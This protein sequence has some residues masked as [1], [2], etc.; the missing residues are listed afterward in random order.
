MRQVERT[1]VHVMPRFQTISED[2][3]A[4]YPSHRQCSRAVQVFIDFM[5]EW[6]RSHHVN[7]EALRALKSEEVLPVHRLS[8]QESV[9]RLKPSLKKWG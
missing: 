1:L 2:F 8:G 9:S 7:M 6:M 5:V 3:Y 4:V